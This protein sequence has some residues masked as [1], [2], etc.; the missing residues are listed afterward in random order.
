MILAQNVNK[1]SD[2]LLICK[3]RRFFSLTNRSPKGKKTVM[4]I[5]VT[6]M[7]QTCAN[8]YF[9]K[10]CNLEGAEGE[11]N[12]AVQVRHQRHRYGT[13]STTHSRPVVMTGLNSESKRCLYGRPCCSCKQNKSLLYTCTSTLKTWEFYFELFYFFT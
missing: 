5:P 11:K 8:D 12:L 10:H 3:K 1:M 4:V 9:C 6:E 2:C 13:Y 7:T